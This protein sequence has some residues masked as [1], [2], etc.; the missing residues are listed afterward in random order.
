MRSRGRVRVGDRTTRTMAPSDATRL[1][2]TSCER[3]S[4]STEHTPCQKYSWISR[5]ERNGK[6]E[7]SGEVMVQQ[8]SSVTDVRVTRVVDRWC[9]SETASKQMMD[10]WMDCLMAA[11]NSESQPPPPQPGNQAAARSDVAIAEMAWN[12]AR[13][14]KCSSTHHTRVPRHSSLTSPINLAHSLGLVGS[15]FLLEDQQPRAIR[16]LLAAPSHAPA[17]PSISISQSHTG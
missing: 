12:T 15:I 2:L 8:W 5:S 3:S 13:P 9:E 14:L 7:S 1:I 10:C 4:S 17:S 16:L 11:R 6:H